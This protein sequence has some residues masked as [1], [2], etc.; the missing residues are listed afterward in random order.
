MGNLNQAVIRV[1][2]LHLP[3]T[4]PSD[5]SEGAFCLRLNGEWLSYVLGSTGMLGVR[6]AWKAT[7]QDEWADI[8]SWLAEIN[9]LITRCDDEPQAPTPA[10]PPVIIVQGGA[11]EQG[12][13]G[14]TIEELEEML[15]MAV[16]KIEYRNGELWYRDGCCDWHRVTEESGVQFVASSV[17]NKPESQTLQSWAD[18][19]KPNLSVGQTPVG[20]DNP[21]YTT[22]DSLAC[23]KATAI[24]EFFQTLLS[25]VKDGVGT[26]A[27]SITG[28]FQ[29]LA[30]VSAL[31]GFE[32]TSL[33]MEFATLV[34]GS[35]TGRTAL[36]FSNDVDTALA[37]THWNDVIC[38]S[39]PKMTPVVTVGFLTGNLVTEADVNAVY[40]EAAARIDMSDD[41]AQVLQTFPLSAIQNKVRQDLP[42]QDC[43]C[44][45]FL[46]YGY[47]PPVPSGSVR[48]TLEKLFN[49]SDGSG[50]IDLP[51]NGDPFNIVDSLS[52]Q[53]GT[54]SGGYWKTTRDKIDANFTFCM[55]AAL[56]KVEGGLVDIDKV[57]VSLTFDTGLPSERTTVWA[58]RFDADDDQWHTP[59]GDDDQPAPS[60][61]EFSVI[62][63]TDNVSYM[64]VII[65][66]QN[67]QPTDKH[68]RVTSVRFDGQF[69]GNPFVNLELGETFTP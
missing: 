1:R 24:T 39:V 6:A 50:T 47:V 21:L 30:T 32:D 8:D 26:S 28:L 58:S 62:N 11:A 34:I 15:Q 22:S 49:A 36:D 19:G 25:E 13:M 31:L 64:A 5:Y 35:I 53:D 67:D 61:T 20:T 16:T 60:R 23:A 56:I 40:E 18:S 29:A 68:A 59:A 54:L 48:F 63:S 14:Y 42:A 57:S 37:D 38:A 27:L 2:K 41:V 43:G 17:I 4:A 46:P 44:E 51:L 66:T 12:T 7:T 65:Y 52:G 33:I 55:G 45:Q 3:V 69:G 9:T 10:P